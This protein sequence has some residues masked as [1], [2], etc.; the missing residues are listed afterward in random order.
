LFLQS[1][2]PWTNIFAIVTGKSSGC[3]KIRLEPIV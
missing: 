1:I 3:P 2:N